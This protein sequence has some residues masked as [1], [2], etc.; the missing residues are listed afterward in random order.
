MK[1]LVMVIPCLLSASLL[2]AGGISGGGPP[3]A[4]NIDER[5]LV[6]IPD[7]GIEKTIVPRDVYRRLALRLSAEKTE[8]TPIILNGDEI[9]V[10]SLR[11]GIVNLEETSQIV[12]SE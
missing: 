11:G 4:A 6:L 12:I 2:R 8:T 7:L 5:T 10:K 1:K 9:Q 3:A